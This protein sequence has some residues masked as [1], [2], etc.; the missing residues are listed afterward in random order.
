MSRQ[1]LIVLNDVGLRW[2]V[3]YPG[4]PSRAAAGPAAH[5]T[6]RLAWNAKEMLNPVSGVFSDDI[7]IDL[8]TANTL[9]HVAGRGIIIDEP[10][11][12][13][14]RAKDTP[15]HVIAVGEAALTLKARSPDP[16][17]L[18]R[19]LRDGVI[20]DFVATEEMLRSFIV[21]AKSKFG[22][23]RPRILIC[24]PAG[25]T[26]VER[27]AVYETAKAAGA[28]RVYLIEEPVAA[29]IGAGI[30][31]DGSG[32]TMILDIG[33]GT[34]DIAVLSK[35]QIVHTA[36]LKVAGNAFDEA[37]R[38]YVRR[39][40]QLGIGLASAERI[41]IEA[42]AAG[43][44]VNG[45]IAEAHIRGRDVVR[46]RIKS[47]VLRPHDVGAA[48]E[49]PIADMAELVRRALE[50]LAPEF[51]VDIDKRGVVMTG[52]GA[53]LNGLDFELTRQL[54]IPFKVAPNPMQCVVGG[55]AIIL[56][57]LGEREQLLV[58]S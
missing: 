36:S 17:E 39:A 44:R 9:V 32:A 27:R 4:I 3:D 33:G 47:V 2:R 31:I 58:H 35:G 11:V 53:L 48:L 40:H 51:R 43:L 38:R 22:F 34:S 16:I 23:R 29:A 50:D 56:A 41:K 46:H 55:T 14:V 13:A 15:R 21:R 7:A 42:G 5:T 57:T 19:P 30:E 6:L 20:A 1:L 8:G 25:S 18:I 10:S 45:H 12:V 37:I 28:R 24:V 54:G 52:G 26:P 49:A